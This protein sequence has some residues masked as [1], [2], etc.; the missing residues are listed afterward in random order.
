MKEVTDSEEIKGLMKSKE[1]VAIFYY[2]AWCPHCKVM[3]EPWG[4]LEKAHSKDM[5]FVKVES[6][7]VPDELGITGFPH[8]VKVKNG[9]IVKEVSGEMPKE[10]LEKKLLSGGGRRLRRTRTRR[11][12]RAT[13]KRLH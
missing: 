11:L 12:R 2:A 5:K 4:E 10:E 7:D 9:G 3:H 6:E 8:F 1:P 13:R